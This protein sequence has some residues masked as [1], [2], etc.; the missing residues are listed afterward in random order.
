MKVTT[1][2]DM[3]RRA[4]IDVIDFGTGEPDFP[5]PDR[6]KAAAR[7][8]IDANFTKYTPN[9]GIADLKRAIADR[10]RGD[11]GVEYSEA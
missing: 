8:A 7:A 6:V 2:V 11:Y 4:G 9:A 10:Y 5:T 1:A 3:M